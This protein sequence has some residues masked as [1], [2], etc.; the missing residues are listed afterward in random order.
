M[1]AVHL[2]IAKWNLGVTFEQNYVTSK[3]EKIEN[4]YAVDC[5]CDSSALLAAAPKLK[6]LKMSLLGV[7]R[8]VALK[9]TCRRFYVLC[10]LAD[11]GA[12]GGAVG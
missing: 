8:S 9:D 1:L 3:P 5:S 2:W 10:V 11:M 4:T 7:G 6:S 12:R